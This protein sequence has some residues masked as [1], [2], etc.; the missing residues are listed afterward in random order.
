[1]ATGQSAKYIDILH[2]NYIALTIRN[3][4]YFDIQIKLESRLTIMNKIKL[5]ITLSL[6]LVSMLG[7]NQAFSKNMKVRIGKIADNKE[8]IIPDHYE[9]AA[10]HEIECRDYHLAV[11]IRTN[12]SKIQPACVNYGTLDSYVVPIEEGITFISDQVKYK[13]AVLDLDKNKIR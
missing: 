8:I 11:F 10:D 5:S 3:K 1:M 12:S 7:S 4:L 9:A 2:Y 6:L 13:D